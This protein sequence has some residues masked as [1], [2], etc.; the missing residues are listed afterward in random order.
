MKFIIHALYILTEVK[1][2][3]C[4]LN[5]RN[6]GIVDNL[7]KRAIEVLEETD[8]EIGHCRVI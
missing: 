8:V 7:P 1:V 3:A 6:L 5:Q 4:A 2:L